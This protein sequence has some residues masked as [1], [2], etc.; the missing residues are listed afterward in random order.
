[1]KMKKENRRKSI[2]IVILI[3]S[4]LLATLLFAKLIN[5]KEAYKDSLRLA[6][7]WT[8]DIA[9][10]RYD[11]VNLD[12]FTILHRCLSGGLR[13]LPHNRIDIHQCP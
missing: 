5:N 4:V 12:A 11:H 13:N 7:E 2:K 10:E 6:E 9:G 1:M 3:L 8:V